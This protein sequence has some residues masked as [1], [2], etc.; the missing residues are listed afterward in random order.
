MCDVMMLTPDT[1]WRFPTYE[2][3]DF[4]RG[5]LI[6]NFAPTMIFHAGMYATHTCIGCH[7][8]DRLIGLRFAKSQIG[9]VVSI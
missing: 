1:G 4:Y 3:H 6:G 8:V 5:S 9:L 2:Q 7:S